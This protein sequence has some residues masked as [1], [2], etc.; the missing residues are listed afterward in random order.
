MLA[1]SGF[2]EQPENPAAP[3]V[4]SREVTPETSGGVTRYVF[5]DPS[6]CRCLYSG[7]E[8]DYARYQAMMKQEVEADSLRA[9]RQASG[10]GAG[11]RN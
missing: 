2:T 4:P 7:S 6:V 5:A 9:I 1:A 3:P 8:A 11:S 10:P